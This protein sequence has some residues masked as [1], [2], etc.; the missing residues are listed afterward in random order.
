MQIF[1]D[2]IGLNLIRVTIGKS[3]RVH[4]F[5]WS[6]ALHSVSR[7]VEDMRARV[8]AAVLCN[9]YDTQARQ[10]QPKLCHWLNALSKFGACLTPSNTPGM[11][12]WYLLHTFCDTTLQTVMVPVL[13]YKVYSAVANRWLTAACKPQPN[14][15]LYSRSCFELE[16]YPDAS[17]SGLECII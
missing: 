2:V 3:H 14:M 17:R 5:M 15:L 13:E 1:D 16:D 9:H 8:Q 7:H 12:F 11:H 4:Q 6:S 10:S